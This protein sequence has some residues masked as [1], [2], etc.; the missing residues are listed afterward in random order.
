MRLRLR[1][2][3][4]AS[5]AI[6]AL[7]LASSAA[8]PTTT[9]TTITTTTTTTTTTKQVKAKMAKKTGHCI[10]SVTKPDTPTTC[11]DTFTAAIAA[12]SGGQITDAPAD[13]RV[14][15]NDQP[16]LARLNATGGKKGPAVNQPLGGGDVL[17]AILFYD[18][19]FGSPSLH[20]F[21]RACNDTIDIPPEN[22]FPFIGEDWN[23]DFESFKGFSNCF[24]RL[25]EHRDFR[26]AMLDWAPERSD[27]GVLNDEVSSL[28]FN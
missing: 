17:I 7:G 20:L 4:L 8:P 6:V 12:G 21:G 5:V 27:F 24:V 18:D 15:M 10:R 22:Q 2:L 28:E 13:T 3:A 23:D 26:G 19:G 9:T 1:T 25:W 14:A 11:Y 16:L